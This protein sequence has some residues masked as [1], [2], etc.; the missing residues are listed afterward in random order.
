MPLLPDHLDIIDKSSTDKP[1]RLV[2]APARNFLNTTFTETASSRQKEERPCVLI[3][4]AVCNRLGIVAG[5]IV[6][7]GNDRGSLLLHALPFDGMQED[8]LIVESQWPN[9]AFIEGIGINVLVSAE[10]GFPAGGAVY[11]DTAVW[12]IRPE[13]Q[14]L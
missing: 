8:T 2:A 9:D 6:R 4:P 3:H 11:H 13:T 14:T 7:I 1:F 10:P 5:V 12:L